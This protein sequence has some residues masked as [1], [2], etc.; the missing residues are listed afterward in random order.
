MKKLIRV[1]PLFIILFALTAVLARA[2]Q[3]AESAQTWPVPQERDFITHAFHFE[4]GETSRGLAS[5][6][7]MRFANSL[8]QTRYLGHFYDFAALHD[9]LN[10]L[11]N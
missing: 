11:K 6:N 3:R 9:E 8:R 7:L 1:R 10:V 5:Q 2:Q 4:S